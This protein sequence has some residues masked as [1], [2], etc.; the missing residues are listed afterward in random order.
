MAQEWP[1]G[2]T[3]YLRSVAVA[4]RSNPTSKERWLHSCRRAER[5]YS[6]FK[7]RRASPEEIP[8][9]KGK[10]QQLRFAGA[11]VKRYLMSQVGETQVR[12]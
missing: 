5:S 9:V 2:A 8:L 6:T 10:E 11:A 7:V 3:P 1:R 12:W 4:E